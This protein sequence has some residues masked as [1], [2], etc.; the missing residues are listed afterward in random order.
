MQN[1][2]LYFR[3]GLLGTLGDDLLYS[4]QYFFINTKTS[5]KY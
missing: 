5:A 3:S 4:F 1:F 2:V